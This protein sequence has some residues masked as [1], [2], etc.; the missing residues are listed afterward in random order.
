[1]KGEGDRERADKHKGG[2]QEGKRSV[3]RRHK[4]IKRYGRRVR[5]GG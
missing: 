1:V 2:V 4:I 3:W 5:M